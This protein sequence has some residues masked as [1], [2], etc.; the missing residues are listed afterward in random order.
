MMFGT[1]VAAA[2]PVPVL[3]KAVAAPAVRSRYIWAVAL[4]H[5]KTDVSVEMIAKQ[6]RVPRAT[7]H[8]LFSQ[9]IKRGVVETPNA[10][11]VARLSA[12]LLRI[13]SQV[14]VQGPTGSAVVKGSLDDTLH[15][16]LDAANDKTSPDVDD[17]I[18][19][20]VSEV[21][22]EVDPADENDPP[23]DQITLS[24]DDPAPPEVSDEA[25]SAG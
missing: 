22:D 16:V 12:P 3:A 20:D 14:M 8:R 1:G 4:A 6:V 13:S 9:L 11:G 19:S 25:H 15:K 24:D 23:E 10:A 7:A 21:K 2:T 5:A 18:E 17:V